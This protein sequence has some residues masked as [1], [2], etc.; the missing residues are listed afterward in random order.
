[1][2]KITRHI[3]RKFFNISISKDSSFYGDINCFYECEVRI[4]SGSK[5]KIGNNVKIKN[6]HINV[7]HGELI[8]GDNSV[9]SDFNISIGNNCRLHIGEFNI[10]E[11]GDNWRKP[12]VILWDG[13]KCKISHHNRIRCDIM[14]RF[15]G[16]CSIDEYNCINE[17]TEIRC[18]EQVSIGSFNM[19]SYNCR[20][21]D[22][23]THSFYEDDTRR[24]MTR[25][26]YPNIGAE[27][28][29]PTTKMV[30]IGD[31]NLVGENSAILK[32]SN[33]SNNI[34]VGYGTIIANNNVKDN[35]T[36]INPGCRI[37]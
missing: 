35:K 3:Y 4:F 15:G 11:Q 25:D 33:I 32:G 19:I 28:D 7:N 22:T 34:K 8:I 27:K 37:V 36:V 6:C 1:M 20:I 16:S 29:K 12:N 24:R 2:N 26:M 13:S 17:R 31:D 5:I 30:Y 10:W 23:N 14:C 21:W 9:L 18:D